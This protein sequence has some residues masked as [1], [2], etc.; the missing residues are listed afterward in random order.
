VPARARLAD[1]GEA[2]CGIIR[3]PD[4]DHTSVDVGSKGVDSIED[5]L[6]TPPVS[7]MITDT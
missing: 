7:S 6:R 5:R 4:C 1:G 3:V 2:R